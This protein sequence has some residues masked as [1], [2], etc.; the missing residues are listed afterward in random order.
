MSA[1]SIKGIKHLRGMVAI[2]AGDAIEARKQEKQAH[3][4]LDEP[5]LTMLLSA[6]LRN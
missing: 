4:L 1:V 2:A 3:V 6:K 5:P